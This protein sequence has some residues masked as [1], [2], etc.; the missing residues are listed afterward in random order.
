MGPLRW[1]GASP[2]RDPLPGSPL[3]DAA[4]RCLDG[5]GVALDHGQ[6]GEPRPVDGDGDGTASCDIGA[7][8]ACRDAVDSDGDGVGDACDPCPEQF[9]PDQ[10]DSDDDGIGDACDVEEVA[11]VGSDPDAEP[12]WIQVEGDGVFVAWE[13]TDVPEWD[14]VIGELHDLRSLGLQDSVRRIR[15]V[16][17]SVVLVEEPGSVFFLVAGRLG[18][19][20]G[21][22]GRDSAGVERELP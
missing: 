15:T 1:R 14:L 6:R 11:P 5:A 18:E 20:V 8:E 12:L 13:A 7:I 22:F 3:I 16:S 9:D 21:S 2:A 10:S 4:S 17:A 19:V